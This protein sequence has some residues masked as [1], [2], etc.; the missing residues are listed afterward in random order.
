MLVISISLKK[1]WQEYK[2]NQGTQHEAFCYTSL[3]ERFEKALV[4]ICPT[5]VEFKFWCPWIKG[6]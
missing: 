1:T 4:D 2:C 6:E 3:K 5:T